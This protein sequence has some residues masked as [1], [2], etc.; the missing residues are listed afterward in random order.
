[1]MMRTKTK[2]RKKTRRRRRCRPKRETVAQRT[3]ARSCWVHCWGHLQPERATTPPPTLPELGQAASQEKLRRGARLRVKLVTS[4]DASPTKSW[5]KSSARRFP[6]QKTVWAT[7]TTVQWRRR[8]VR[9]ITIDGHWRPRTLWPIRTEN[10]WK[11]RTQPLTRVARLWKR[12]KVWPIKTDAPWK[13]RTVWPIK[14]IDQ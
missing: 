13:R 14:T 4:A 2:M 1:M 10:H 9:P 8:T 3:K 12:K 11:P 5:A 6:R 7:R